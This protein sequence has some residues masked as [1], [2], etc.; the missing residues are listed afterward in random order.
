M[1][2]RKKF[3]AMLFFGEES[4]KEFASDDLLEVMKEAVKINPN[5]GFISYNEPLDEPSIIAMAKGVGLKLLTVSNQ[6][7]TIT[8]EPRPREQKK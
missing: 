4:K 8:L 3:R 7:R 2:A 6:F 1:I 5:H